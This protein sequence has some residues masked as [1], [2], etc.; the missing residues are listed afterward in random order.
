M[1]TVIDVTE[2]NAL[3]YG[4]KFQ[5]NLTHSER[6]QKRLP[7]GKIIRVS[8]DDHY[9][10]LN[11]KSTEDYAKNREQHSMAHNRI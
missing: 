9:R 2:G 6:N 1:I 10:K 4:R 8:P 3:N 7:G 11:Q 5:W